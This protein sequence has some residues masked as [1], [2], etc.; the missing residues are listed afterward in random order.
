MEKISDFDSFQSLCRE[1]VI[2]QRTNSNP[3]REYELN[4][5]INYIFSQKET[6]EYWINKIIEYINF[7]DENCNITEPI[8]LN[9]TSNKPCCLIISKN[10]V[11]PILTSEDIMDMKLGL[12]TPDYIIYDCEIN[13]NEDMK[14][15]YSRLRSLREVIQSIGLPTFIKFFL[16]EETMAKLKEKEQK[17]NRKKKLTIIKKNTKI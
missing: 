4:N 17:N 13:P 9:K 1:R 15:Y 2:L 14:D 6:N 5:L 3:K 8:L 12:K 10:A 11:Y 7:N 16:C